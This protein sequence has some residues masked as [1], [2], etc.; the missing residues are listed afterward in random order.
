MPPLNDIFLM[1]RHTG[2]FPYQF[3]SHTFALSLVI[4]THD[5]WDPQ[6][7]AA[8]PLRDWLFATS[9]RELIYIGD[10]T[11]SVAVRTSNASVFFFKG[12]T[13]TRNRPTCCDPPP[14]T[15][16]RD[17]KKRAS[18]LVSQTHIDLLPK[19]RRL[20]VTCDSPTNSLTNFCGRYHRC[21]SHCHPLLCNGSKGKK[22]SILKKT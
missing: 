1:I 3:R 15:T 13:P 2:H 20:M 11:F 7:I 6:S 17:D 14:S 4:V 12:P 22:F 19:R 10:P 9:T 21:L 16:T 5:P 18:K 8:A